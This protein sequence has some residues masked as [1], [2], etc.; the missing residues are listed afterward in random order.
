MDQDTR[1]RIKAHA[2]NTTAAI[3]YYGGTIS[4]GLAFYHLLNNT[5]ALAIVTLIVFTLT[6]EGILRA[7]IDEITTAITNRWTP[8]LPSAPKGA[9]QS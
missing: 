7:L 3:T 4:A 1:N 9:D 2:L 8:A 5:N 6:V